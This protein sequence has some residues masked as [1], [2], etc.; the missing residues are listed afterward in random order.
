MNEKFHQL[1]EEKQLAIFNAAME[2]F[3]QNDYK[4]AS[5]DDIAAKA[6][7]SKGMLFF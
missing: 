6:G 2:V 1:P 4:R 7:I 5:T 3:A